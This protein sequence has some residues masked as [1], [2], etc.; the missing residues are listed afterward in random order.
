MKRTGFILV[1]G[2]LL[3]CGGAGARTIVEPRQLDGASGSPSVSR[4][5]DLG[6]MGLIPAQGNPLPAAD[7]DGEFAVGELVLI[8]GSEFGK[9]PTLNLGGRP[10]EVLARTGSGGILARVPPGV[11]TG[12]IDV[13]VSHTRGRGAKPIEVVR[14]GLVVQPGAGKVHVLRF[15]AKGALTTAGSIDV[16]GARDVAISHDGV[17]AYVVAD[18]VGDVRSAQLAIIALTA[19]GGPKLLRSLRL[20]GTRAELVATAHRAARGIV[21]GDGRVTVFNSGNATSPALYDAVP[22]RGPVAEAGPLTEAAVHQEG[23]LAVVLS[24][25]GNLLVPIDIS[26]PAAAR[27]QPALQ[28]L[29]DERVPLVRDLGFAPKG[30]ELWVVAGDNETSLIGGQHAPRLIILEVARGALTLVRSVDLGGVDA[31]LALAV[32]RRESVGSATAIRSVA[33]RAAIIA[34][35]IDRAVLEAVRTDGKPDSALAQPQPIGHLARTD[36]E[37]KSEQVWRDE[38]AVTDVELTED[39]RFIVSAGSRVTRAADGVGYELGVAVTPLAGGSTAFQVL[40]PGAPG[41]T[42]LSRA[43]IALSP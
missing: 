9:L 16:P 26:N 5:T 14:Y 7:S 42:L 23:E 19:S 40:G 32:A 10:A 2:A 21:V 28:L 20:S 31:P 12:T 17:A 3:G 22:L 36:L 6:E 34:T 29:P 37:G 13:E 11:P 24:A 41:T 8:E 30:E 38:V 35:S 1:V 39:V 4:V 15:G 18:A 33:R 43:A 27:P 25:R